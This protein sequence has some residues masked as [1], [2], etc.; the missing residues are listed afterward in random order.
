MNKF[1][2]FMYEFVYKRIYHLYRRIHKICL[3]IRFMIQDAIFW[4]L[5]QIIKALLRFY[6]SKYM[7]KL[8]EYAGVEDL[9]DETLNDLCMECEDIIKD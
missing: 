9:Y 3:Q 8:Y 2:K 7:L 5:K 6:K 1:L 4:I